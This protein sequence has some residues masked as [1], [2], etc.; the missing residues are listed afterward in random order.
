M[1]FW[2]FLFRISPL[3]PLS[4]C[5]VAWRL[6]ENRYD[7]DNQFIWIIEIFF[8]VSNDSYCNAEP[9][10]IS[11]TILQQPENLQMNESN[12]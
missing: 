6:F 3:P 9:K 12:I 10:I 11:L 1:E 4:Y 8:R 5:G 2:K 7:F